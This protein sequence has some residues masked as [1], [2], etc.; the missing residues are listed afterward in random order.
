MASAS[1]VTG[2]PAG[3]TAAFYI[4]AAAF[5]TVTSNT[6]E[7]KLK[8]KYKIDKVSAVR[9]AYTYAQTK[10]VDWS[11]DTMQIGGGGSGYLPSNELAPDYV[12]QTLG[13]SYVYT[14]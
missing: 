2:A 10:V 6:V 9:F 1:T 11:F 14:F 12:V 13:I 4:P 8:G 5:P 7:L 3:V